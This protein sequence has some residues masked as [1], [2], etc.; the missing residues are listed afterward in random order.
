MLDKMEARADILLVDDTP[1][2]LRLLSTALTQHGY[3]VRSVINGRMALMGARAAP[4]DLILLDICMPGMSGYEVC[5]Q[6]KSDP[7]T[8]KVPVLFISALDEVLDKVK[9]FSVGGVDFI[10]KPFHFEE[11]IARVENQLTI[12]LLQR[13]LTDLNNQLEERVKQRTEELRQ[14]ISE[15]KK[16]Q[17]QLLHIAQHDALT[18]LPNR[19][20][21]MERL[22][23]TLRDAQSHP[24]YNFAVL[25]LDCDRFK[26]VNDSLGHRIGDL[27]LVAVAKRLKRCLRSKDMLARM[28]G[29]EF[30]VL[31]HDLD[32]PQ[33][34][35]DIA[36]TMNHRLSLAFHVEQYEIFIN[37][38]IGVVF[39]REQF[40]Q[41]LNPEKPRQTPAFVYGDAEHLLR[42]ADTAMYQAKAEGKGR[43]EV[44]NIQM[45][46]QAMHLLQLENDLRRALDNREFC[47][48]YQ[49]IVSLATG[50]IAGF[51]A[52]VRWLHP[53]Q[54]F[55]PPNVFIPAA[56]ETGLILPLGDWILQ[57]ACEQLKQWH[58][59]R[60]CS[61][62]LT[63][64]VNLSV[65]Q[66]TQTNILEHIERILVETKVQPDCLKLEVTE[67][68][69]I[70]QP[71]SIMKLLQA[72][73]N[74]ELQ[75]SLD[76]F[77]TGYSSLSYLH[78][79]PMDVL[80]IDQSFVG[81]IDEAPKNLKIVQA[82]VTL[83]QNL[84]MEAIAEGVETEAQLKC[85][86]Q[87]GCEYGQGYYF[88]PPL[89]A[90]EAERLLITNPQW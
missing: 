80:K 39:N 81:H 66:F 7:L 82:I 76:D 54:G 15:R 52:L 25:F 70:D 19:S 27:L 71:E 58:D 2:N 36:Q 86:R 29:D 44:F 61:Q 4:P 37:A 46:E 26:R 69:L 64:S 42:D 45:H 55:I 62:P 24:D 13:S 77:G 43:Y 14:E 57:T 31:V 41:Q 34:V 22:E 35:L 33:Q 18:Q 65:R 3:K 1:E 38:S 75:L 9:A 68:V 48:H 78:R 83:A 72:L 67:S 17:E 84:S 79:F 28:G 73:K 12:Q 11:V 8:Q 53:Q 10:T 50:Q 30:A 20:L 87:L 59:E 85:L 47:L 40:Y 5:Q 23:S 32:N 16:A 49:P 60:L 89:A 88:S 21:M 51:E 6:L 90:P 63:M 74:L 56:E